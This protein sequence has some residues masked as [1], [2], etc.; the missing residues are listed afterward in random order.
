M[1]IKRAGIAFLVLLIVIFTSCSKKGDE[2]MFE[3]N[4]TVTFETTDK[5][6][7]NPYMGFAVSADNEDAVGENSLVYI[8]VTFRE[9]QPN[10]PHEFDFETIAE[11]NN[12]EMWKKQGKHAVLRFVCDRPDDE[13]HSDIPHW[14]ME[15]TG[16]GSFY[17]ISYGKGYCPDY[18]NEIFIEYHKNAVKALAEYFDDGFVSYV[19][20]GSL[21]HW[22][23]WHIKSDVGIA[24]PAED[25]RE[26]YVSHYTDSFSNAR[27]MMRR[28]FNSVKENNM[29]L[30]NDMIGSAEAT[31]E[32]L[33]WIKYGGEYSQTGEANAMSA[34]PD[35]WKTAPSGGEFTSSVPMDYMCGEGLA[36]TVEMLEKSH[37]TFIGPKTPVGDQ[38]ATEKIITSIG[39]RLGITQVN[40][41][42]IKNSDE[43]ILKMEWQNAGT[44][45]LYFDL[46]VNLYVKNADGNF[47]EL[48]KVDI[49]LS[50]IL[51]DEKMYSET[52]ISASEISENTTLYVGITDP[53]N[54][55]PAVTLVSNQSMIGKYAEIYSFSGQI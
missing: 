11:E 35:F 13:E 9:L 44:A 46:P 38:Y 18:T 55:K 6:V 37:T 22:G 5:A 39:Y 19:Q 48:K 26:E 14:L 32:W 40:V 3:I 43:I 20:L 33:D 34:V 52:V 53:M 27:L 36:E 12:I 25:V 23:E 41:S 31:N 29:G 15:L 16:D 51:P 2:V 24:M 1:N 54:G 28:P 8:D 49:K 17:D 10:S 50:E 42:K 30:Y 21:G 45:P 4:D 47:A 7:V